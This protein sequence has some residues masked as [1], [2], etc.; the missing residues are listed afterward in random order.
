MGD[1]EWISREWNLRR[2]MAPF[3][4]VAFVVRRAGVHG[5]GFLDGG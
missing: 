1:V 2:D 4:R 5:R 3:L